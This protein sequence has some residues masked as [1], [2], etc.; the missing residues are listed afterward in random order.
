MKK[1]FGFAAT[2]V[3]LAVGCGNKQQA[4]EAYK[5][6]VDDYANIMRRV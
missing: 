6:I 4:E 1:W 5:I 3:L 2:L